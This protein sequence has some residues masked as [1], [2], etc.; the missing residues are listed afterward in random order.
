M[1][2]EFCQK[3]FCIYFDDYM[4]SILQFFS[5]LY[6]TRI[7]M[8]ILDHLC[9]PGINPTWFW[10]VILFMHCSIQLVNIMLRIFECFHHWYWHIFFFSVFFFYLVLKSRWC[11]PHRVILEVSLSLNFLDSLRRI[12]V[13]TSLNFLTSEALVV[14]TCQP[15]QET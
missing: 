12:G 11:F 9:I 1:N 2:V 13:N 5:M 14:K 7:D 6:I 10:C 4:T 8:G 3:P 15:V